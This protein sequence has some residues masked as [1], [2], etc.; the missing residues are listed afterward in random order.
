VTP[1]AEILVEGLTNPR[2]LGL[3]RFPIRVRELAVTLSAWRLAAASDDGEGTITVVELSPG[4]VFHRGD[5]VFLGWPQDRL[6][7]AYDA[8]MPR[9]E[10]ASAMEMPQLG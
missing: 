7:S 3:A 8:L 6:S 2:G 10:A 5:G 1:P 4:S 9:D